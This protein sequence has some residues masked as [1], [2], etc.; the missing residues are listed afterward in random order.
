M[1]Y[2]R[3]SE[4]DFYVYATR[5]DGI[6]IHG[7]QDDELS[8]TLQEALDYLTAQ[9]DAGRSVPQHALDRLAREISEDANRPRL[10]DNP[11]A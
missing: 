3:W 4:S 6:C 2:C 9:R 10:F 7:P 11:Q 1:A 8:L 5:R